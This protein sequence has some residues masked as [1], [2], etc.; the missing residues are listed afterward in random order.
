[1]TLEDIMLSEISQSQKNKYYRIPFTQ[2]PWSSQIHRDR[3]CNGGYKGLEKERNGGGC[4]LMGIKFQ[5]CKV[6]RV[7]EIGCITM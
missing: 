7:L 2:G 5:F 3:K 6:K 4:C 1:M